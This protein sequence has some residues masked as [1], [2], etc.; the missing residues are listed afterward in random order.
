M[1]KIA[2]TLGV[3]SCCIRYGKY[4]EFKRITYVIMGISLVRTVSENPIV[5]D[6]KNVLFVSRLK[7]DEHFN[8]EI[9][10]IRL[11][12]LYIYKER[13][14]LSRYRSMNIG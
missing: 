8:F 6:T 11:Y 3:H 2:Y 7:W 5:F 12:K 10:E 9:L 4:L 1:Y 14:M 13:K